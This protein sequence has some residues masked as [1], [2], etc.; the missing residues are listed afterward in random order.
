[1]HF[2]RMSRSLEMQSILIVTIVLGQLSQGS[3]ASPISAEYHRVLDEQNV[4]LA[5][6]KASNG[7]ALKVVAE[8]ERQLRAIFEAGERDDAEALGK[9]DW[10]ALANC[11]IRLREHERALPFALQA[12]TEAQTVVSYAPLVRCLCALNRVDDAERV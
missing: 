11:A 5:N 3:Q 6:R 8:T 2:G 7:D 4:K 10:L 12:A 9:D 1:M